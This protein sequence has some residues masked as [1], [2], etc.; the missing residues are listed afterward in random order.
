MVQNVGNIH[1]DEPLGRASVLLLS[2]WL[3]YNYKKDPTVRFFS[4]LDVIDLCALRS[5]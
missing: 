5:K 4:L 1:G 3:C 2:D